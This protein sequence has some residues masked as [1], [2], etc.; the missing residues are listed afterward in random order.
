MV[1]NE[2]ELQSSSKMSDCVAEVDSS[3]LNEKRVRDYRS[4]MIKLGSE[5]KSDDLSK[6]KYF[7]KGKIPAGK[8]EGL[9]KPLDLFSELEDRAVIGPGK[10]DKLR[11]YLEGIDRPSLISM[12]DEF[13]DSNSAFPLKAKS[14]NYLE[15]NDYRVSIKEGRHFETSEGEFVEV[16]SGSNY[17]LTI[18]NLNGHRCI[19]TVSID[20]CDM[21]PRGFILNAKGECTIERPDREN[22]RFK[23][24]ATADAP[25]RS[26]INKWRRDLNGLIEVVFTPEMADMK[27]TCVA[28]GEATQ[29]LSCSCE[30]TDS[31]L[32]EMVSGSFGVANVT[33]MINGWKPLGMR[34]KKL[35]EYGIEDGSQVDVNLGGKGGV[36]FSSTPASEKRVV[37]TKDAKWRAGASA[38]GDESQQKFVMKEVF[39]LESA[40]AVSL[41][42]RLVAREDVRCLP[43]TGECT[44]LARATLIP[45]P[46]PA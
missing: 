33:I 26:G 19:C 35:I 11:S 12:V 30:S 32:Y 6:L 4:F 5:M 42:L 1:E 37:S 20:G 28:R 45:P 10:L 41:N 43:S 36:S 40:L 14:Q 31:D 17:T 46:V 25:D 15:T 38:L 21:F 7:L 39:P 13:D 16:R 34:G 2:Q 22:K 8:M 23:F 9:N 3:M 27:I 29:V 44:P 24:F 18:T